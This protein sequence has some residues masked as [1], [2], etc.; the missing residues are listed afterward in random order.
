MKQL[1]SEPKIGLQI[2]CSEGLISRVS[3]SLSPAFTC[4][5]EGAGPDLENSILSWLIAYTKKS[6]LPLPEI[7]QMS[8]LTPFQKTGLEQMKTISFGETKSYKELAALCKKP[9]GARAIGGMCSRNPF[10]LFYPCHR[11]ICSDKSL[12][13]FAVDLEIKRR[14]LDFEGKH[15]CPRKYTARD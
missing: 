10:L 12:G 9:L 6:L 8:G 5:I 13:G 1:A 3:A 14:L 15:P 2:F 4:H 7:F 11:V